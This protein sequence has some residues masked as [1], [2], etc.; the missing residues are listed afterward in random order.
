MDYIDLHK[1]HNDIFRK[2]VN[3]IN[4]ATKKVDIEF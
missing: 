4:K 1:S 3:I 2:F